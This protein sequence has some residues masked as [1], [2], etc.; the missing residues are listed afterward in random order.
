MMKRFLSTLLAALLCLGVAVLPAAAEDATEPEPTVQTQEDPAEPV[1]PP[2]ETAAP[3]QEEPTAP[4]AETH[5]PL[6]PYREPALADYAGDETAFREDHQAW[7][8]SVYARYYHWKNSDEMDWRA[9]YDPAFRA[10]YADDPD[11]FVENHLV[12]KKLTAF[13]YENRKRVKRTFAVI[14]DYFD[15]DEAEEFC[16]TLRIPALLDGC[17]VVI[18][19]YYYPYDDMDVTGSVGYSNDTVKKLVLEE[20]LTGVSS[21]AFAD[22]TALRTV[23]L[24]ASL[25]SVNRGAFQ[26]CTSLKKVVVRGELERIGPSAFE[27]CEC[28]HR[29]DALKSVRYLDERAFADSGLRSAT[30]YGGVRMTSGEEDVAIGTFADCKE[31]QTV[32]FTDTDPE[33]ARLGLDITWRCFSGCT[34]LQTVVLPAVC[35]QVSIYENAFEG[36][37]A[38]RKV[39]QVKNLKRIYNNAFLNCT[40]LES[41]TLPKGIEFAEDDAF[42]G[43]TGLQRLYV[44]SKNPDLLKY[45][46]Y[47]DGDMRGREISGNFL[48]SVPKHC[49]IFVANKEMKYVF[50]TTGYKGDVRIRVTVPA[51]KTARLTKQ[52][53]KV[54]FRWSKVKTADGYRIWSFDPKTG[55]YTKLATVKAPQT[56]VTLKTNARQF[57]IRTYQKEAGD[58]SWSLVKTFK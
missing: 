50:K 16:T 49:M 28:L 42:K 54:A 25:K 4:A 14:L 18:D 19:M 33:D 41:F 6:S 22:F 44:H 10:F 55:K 21:F 11:L 47:D 53:G 12:F 35:K 48:L 34:A 38:L 3:A 23:S 31:L 15:T 45:K 13:V 24:P 27:G 1:S 37:T 5:R 20:G 52:G 17:A 29:F 8:D 2:E 57:V 30:L 32:R 39:T 26:N 43:C 7:L 40:A 36:C 46:D 58:V 9:P 56:S 51:P